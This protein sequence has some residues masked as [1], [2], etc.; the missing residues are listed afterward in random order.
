[1]GGGL[2]T[3]PSTHMSYSI[4]LFFLLL[5]Q[6]V[7]CEDLTEITPIITSLGSLAPFTP[8]A[9]CFT[10]SLWRSSRFYDDSNQSGL[11]QTRFFSRWYVGCNVDDDTGEINT[12]CP[13]RYRTWGFYAPGVCPQGY[14]TVPT[15]NV[16]P[17]VGDQRGTVCCPIVK[18]PSTI[19]LLTADFVTSFI[20]PLNRDPISISCFEWASSSTS[21]GI[22]FQGNY[23][24]RAI[25]VFGSQLTSVTF[26][27]AE[28]DGSLPTPTPATSSTSSSSAGNTSSEPLPTSGEPPSPGSSTSGATETGSSLGSSSA[29]SP[30]TTDSSSSASQNQGSEGSRR[31]GLSGGAIAGIAI[32]VAVPVIAIAAYIAYRLGRRKDDIPVVPIYNDPRPKE[33][34]G[35]PIQYIRPACSS[36]AGAMSDTP[37]SRPQSHQ[38]GAITNHWNDLPAGYIPSP[39]NSLSRSASRNS[40]TLATPNIGS[41]INRGAS[42]SPLRHSAST[43][44]DEIASRSEGDGPDSSR[45]SGETKSLDVLLPAL[46]NLPTKLARNEHGMLQTRINKSLLPAKG[47]GGVTDSQK[48]WIRELLQGFVV[49]G[50][51]DGK[52][53]RE[54]IIAFMR[55]ESGVAG[56]AASVRK[57]VESVV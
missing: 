11:S 26:Q 24:A 29:G 47:D 17:W 5:G 28:A 22:V 39:T 46:Y 56:W 10:T 40:N 23:N 8:P 50:A 25:I 48:L 14:S 6:Q 13:P 35:G 1:M 3:P 41:S 20:N 21:R 36:G 30:S 49:D 12:C 52:Q 44:K 54:E 57:V 15:N 19:R 18:D 43:P 31:T 51:M 45:T 42:A 2:S 53:A 9:D 33:G 27:F 34:E 55:R 32:G 37:P 4:L 7:V 38:K 16:N